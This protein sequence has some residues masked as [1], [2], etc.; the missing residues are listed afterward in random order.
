M[1]GHT[2]IFKLLHALHTRYCLLNM[3]EKVQQF[4]SST[5]TRCAFYLN[6]FA[7]NAS[8]HQLHKSTTRPTDHKVSLKLIQ[9]ASCPDGTAISAKLLRRTCSHAV[10]SPSRFADLTL[11]PC[12]KFADIFHTKCSLTAT[13]LRQKSSA[14]TSILVAELMQTASIKIAHLTLKN[15][16]Q[17]GGIERSH[18]KIKI[19]LKVNVKNDAPQ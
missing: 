16:Q 2:D 3:A 14:F 10:C 1:P 11:L 19:I 13:N 5:T 7:P 12:S 18:Q 8:H 9:L 4:V 6:H 15:A 17:I